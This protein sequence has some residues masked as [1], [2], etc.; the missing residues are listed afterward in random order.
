[1]YNLMNINGLE[2]T[3]DALQV[4]FSSFMANLS[5]LDRY[6]QVWKDVSQEEI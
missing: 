3:L 4:F 2:D 5:L 1:M 6:Q